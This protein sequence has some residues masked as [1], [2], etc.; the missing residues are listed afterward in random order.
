M[1]TP[2]ADGLI[3]PQSGDPI[4]AEQQR[5]V[6]ALL[7]RQFNMPD[8]IVDVLGVRSMQPEIP[9]RYRRFTLTETLNAGSDADVTW[10]DGTAGTVY[11]P[12]Y[13]CYGLTGETGEAVRMRVDGEAKWVVTKN[14][15]Q[16]IYYGVFAGN[17]TTSPTNVTI[18]IGGVD[19]TV[20]ATVAITIPSGKK[21]ASGV[22]CYVGHFRGAWHVVSVVACQVDT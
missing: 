4:T 3:D 11:D 22:K 15:G 2:G 14:P 20:S 8:T 19:R 12:D 16:P 21:Y 6:N 7:R 1:L 10:T 17:V 5:L 18:A 13:C 9:R